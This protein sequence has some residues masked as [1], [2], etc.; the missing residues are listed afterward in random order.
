MEVIKGRVIRGENIGEK[1]GYPTANLSPKL[2]RGKKI[3]KGVYFAIAEVNNKIYPALVIVGVPGYKIQKKGKLEVYFLGLKKNIYKKF[4][5]LKLL[6]KL[7]SL[8]ITNDRKKIISRIRK[9]IRA[10]KDFFKNR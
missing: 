9:D 3:S 6:K 5:K 8:L 1:Q 7:R 2:L 4:V 10:A